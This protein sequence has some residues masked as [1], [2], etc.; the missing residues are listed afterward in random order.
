MNPDKLSIGIIGGSGLYEILKNPESTNI[1]TP[2]TKSPVIIQKEELHDRILYFLPRHGTGHNIPPHMINYKANIFAL[3]KVGC[4]CVLSTNA[5]GS[6]RDDYNPGDYVVIDQFMDFVRPI[7]FFDGSFSINL[8]SGE[9]LFG[10]VHTDVTEPYASSLRDVLVSTAQ[11]FN[12]TVHPVGTYATCN[13]PRFETPAEI[14]ALQVLGADVVGMTNSSEAT[15]CN[16]IKLKYATITLITNFGSGL[17]K[18]VSHEEVIEMF[19]LK[20]KELRK[21]LRKTALSI[22]NL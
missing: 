1:D 3:Y 22:T 11:Q 8:R 9:K 14:K 5:V 21:I 17:Q 2:F 18:K 12:S 20:I 16:E 7:T 15:L 4:D 19:N 10:V 6:L 13:G